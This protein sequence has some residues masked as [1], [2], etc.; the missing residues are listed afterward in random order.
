MPCYRLAD[1]DEAWQALE[2]IWSYEEDVKEVAASSRRIG[3]EDIEDLAKL[4]EARRRKV[5]MC[6]KR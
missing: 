3:Q 1:A 2:D 4:L 6:F 5:L